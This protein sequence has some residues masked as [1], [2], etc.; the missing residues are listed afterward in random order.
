ME[1]PEISK[2]DAFNDSH[3]Y[4]CRS[5]LPTQLP[6][7]CNRA[8]MVVFLAWWFTEIHNNI[9]LYSRHGFEIAFELLKGSQRTGCQTIIVFVTDG[10]DTDG[11]QVRCGPGIFLADF[12]HNP[13]CILDHYYYLLIFG[14]RILAFRVFLFLLNNVFG[15]RGVI[16]LQ[17]SYK[18]LQIVLLF[19]CIWNQ[20]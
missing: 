3:I 19:K 2:W 13:L 18:P 12:P 16:T 11:E 10:Q 7:D 14:F 1:W 4:Q 8:S 17:I 20:S 9:L 15:L 5:T 6:M